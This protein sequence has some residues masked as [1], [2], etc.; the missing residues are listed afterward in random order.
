MLLG[1]AFLHDR[2]VE[3]ELVQNSGSDVRRLLTDASVDLLVLR[4]AFLRLLPVL[5]HLGGRPR[6]AFARHLLRVRLADDVLVSV[7]GR[8]QDQEA[9]ATAVLLV[10]HGRELVV[11]LEACG[12]RGVPEERRA[13]ARFPHGTMLCSAAGETVSSLRYSRL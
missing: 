3:P 8:E 7:V 13:V 10:G 2:G 11:V 12:G 6:L 1:E 4:L 9:E 5:G